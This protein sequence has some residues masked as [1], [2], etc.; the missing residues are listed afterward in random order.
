[1]LPSSLQN[2]QP[3]ENVVHFSLA[4]SASG[5]EGAFLNTVMG[6]VAGQTQMP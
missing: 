2:K 5:L 6:I 1:M 3:K 4:S